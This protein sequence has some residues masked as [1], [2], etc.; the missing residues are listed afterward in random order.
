MRGPESWGGVESWESH[1]HTTEYSLECFAEKGLR[2]S[3]VNIA[4]TNRVCCDAGCTPT[5]PTRS[6]SF[7]TDVKEAVAMSVARALPG[8]ARCW[9]SRLVVHLRHGEAFTGYNHRTA[10]ALVPLQSV[11]LA[12]WCFRALTTSAATC[13][14]DSPR[15]SARLPASSGIACR[16]S[17]RRACPL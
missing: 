6:A 12:L 13:A 2:C 7:R 17:S 5:A 8:G 3:E 10:S 9:R 14:A 4:L 16:S 15:T 11:E 1:C